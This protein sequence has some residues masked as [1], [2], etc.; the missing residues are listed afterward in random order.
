[1]MEANAARAAY[2]GVEVEFSDK[3]DFKFLNTFFSISQACLYMQVQFEKCKVQKLNV[4]NSF[5]GPI[6]A[7][8]QCFT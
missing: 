5:L 4:S 8:G 2:E 6:C 7:F 1:M 3:T